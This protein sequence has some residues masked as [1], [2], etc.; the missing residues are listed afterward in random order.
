MEDREE[1]MYKILMVEDDEII[2]ESVKL[3]LQ[4]W[5][6]EVETVKAFDKVVETFTSAMPQLVLMDIG[7]PFFNGYH[8]YTEIRKLS[9]VPIIFLSSASDNMNIVMAMNMGADDFITKPFDLEIL[10]AK[11]QAMI[12]RTYDFKGDYGLLE[13]RGVWLNL[14]DAS[15][16]INGEKIELTKNE[17]RILEMLFQNKGRVVSR[18]ELMKR[19]WDNACFVDDNTL[20]VNMT[21]IRKKLEEAGI[22]KLITT[23]KGMGYLLE[24]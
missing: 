24:E 15:M 9:K 20:T 19:L 22:S 23:K 3:H 17:F 14:R 21:R 4:K 10:S 12:R 2:C 7:L 11:V 16:Q 6:Y 18:D 8:W 5:G 1:A 13:H